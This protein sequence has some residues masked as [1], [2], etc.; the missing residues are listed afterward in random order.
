MIINFV[1]FIFICIFA[2]SNRQDIIICNNMNI[3]RNIKKMDSI[4]LGNYILKHYGPMSHLKLQKLVFYCD[5]YHLAYFGEELVDDQF[6]AWVH[7]PVSRKLYNSLKDKSILYSD[8][9]YSP[10]KGIDEDKLFAEL[11]SDQQSLLKEVLDTLSSWTALELERAT[12]REKPWIDARGNIS[13]AEKSNAIISKE[14]MMSFYRKE[15][16]M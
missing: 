4:V 15:L 7:G 12:H 8:I 2:T 13:I 1:N 11:S 16:T 3:V 5:A 14:E 9:A 6:E 10:I